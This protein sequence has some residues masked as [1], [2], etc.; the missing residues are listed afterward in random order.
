MIQ[1]LNWNNK[2]TFQQLNAR[3]EWFSMRW[4]CFFTVM[5]QGFQCLMLLIITFVLCDL[6]LFLKAKTKTKENK[7]Y[8]M[9]V[10]KNNTKN[11]NHKKATDETKLKLNW[12]WNV[13]SD[14]ENW[15][16]NFKKRVNNY[17][18]VDLNIVAVCLESKLNR[19][20]PPIVKCGKVNGISFGMLM[21]T[22]CSFSVWKPDTSW[23]QATT[24][25]Q[26]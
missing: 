10:I 2:N 18:A 4:M 23:C 8:G 22:S 24:R 19:T 3:F 14:I 9:E 1:K 12:K 25:R 16:T 21:L 7:N 5:F 11:R 17:L 15:K 6:P 20:F 26:R 13:E